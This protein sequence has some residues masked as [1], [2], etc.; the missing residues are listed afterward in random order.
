MGVMK[1]RQIRIRLASIERDPR[2]L[3]PTA[4]TDTNAALALVQLSLETQ[5]DTLRF[6]LGEPIVAWTILRREHAEKRAA[7]AK[8]DQ[9]KAR[10]RS[11]AAA[12]LG[13]SRG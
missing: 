8:A 12:P 7:E 13:G 3:Y 4:N 1:E 2:L 10:G 5:S 9:A 6:V 11:T